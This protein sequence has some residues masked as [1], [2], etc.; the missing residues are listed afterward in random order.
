MGPE[1]T[2]AFAGALLEPALRSWLFS[3]CT[4]SGITSARLNH[5]FTP[6]LGNIPTP[7]SC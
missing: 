2:A 1:R 4:L 3:S 7:V 6:A 5:L